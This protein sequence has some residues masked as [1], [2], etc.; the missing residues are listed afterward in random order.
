MEYGM[1]WRSL[2]VALAFCL[3]SLPLLA[4]QTAQR[5]QQPA[6]PTPK[7]AEEVKPAAGWTTFKSAEGGF[8]ISMPEEPEQTVEPFSHARFKGAAKSH[9]FVSFDGRRLYVVA[10]VDFPP[11]FKPEAE[12]ELTNSRAIFVEKLNAKLGSS[13]RIEFERAPG[14]AVPAE[15]FTAADRKNFD[16]QVLTVFDGRR[17]IQ[18]AAGIPK[19]EKAD[20]AEDVKNFFASFKLE[21]PKQ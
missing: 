11:E 1:L 8:S 4:Q 20:A 12:F 9:R 3:M 14:D 19:N 7:P 15:E 17:P 10:F 13:K 2:A 18:V 21:P 5:A 6:K 16:Y